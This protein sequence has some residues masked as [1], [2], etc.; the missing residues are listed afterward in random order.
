MTPNTNIVFQLSYEKSITA[1]IHR[2]KLGLS[3]LYFVN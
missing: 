1:I 2:V 3:K